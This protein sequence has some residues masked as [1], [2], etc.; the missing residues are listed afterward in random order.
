MANFGRLFLR[1][2]W[3]NLRLVMFESIITAGLLCMS[4]MSPFF[5]SIGLS[6][7]EIALSQAIYTVVTIFL[8]F[9]TGWLAD[10]FSRKWANVIGDIGHAVILIRYA[11]ADSFAE[12][13]VCEILAG[14]FLSLSKGV[15]M[16]LLR[17]FANKVDSSGSLFQT[18]A[19]KLAFLQ[20]IFT[21]I[22]M[23][24][25]GPIGAISFRLAIAMSSM[26]YFLGGFAALLIH[27]DSEKLKPKYKSPLRDMYTI[28]KNSLQ[29]KRLR[30]RIAAYTIGRE[31]THV[32]IWV[33]TPMLI[34]V[35][36]PLPIVSF[37]WAMNSLACAFGAKIATRLVCK[38][39]D[40]QRFMIPFTLMIISMGTI[41]L[42]LNILTIWIYLLM[43]VSQGWTSATFSPMVQEYAKSDEQTS[44]LSFAST[45]GKFIYIPTIWLTGVVAD[46]DLRYAPFVT[47]VIFG[48]LGS[49]V[50]VKLLRE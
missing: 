13:V 28:A 24:L 27:D 35:G 31:M 41:S 49:I 9:P 3:Q 36:I 47:L 48:T 8:F 37:A 50:L 19:A 40:W 32:I 25:G 11:M 23:L 16:S 12:V 7:E 1:D 33:F 44:I 42:S 18:Q 30:L 21:L 4:I 34:F 20:H 5:L 46:L 10:R 15:D 22:L 38:L 6:Q 17:N 43:G 29:N 2:P 26:P 14:V 45:V 39:K